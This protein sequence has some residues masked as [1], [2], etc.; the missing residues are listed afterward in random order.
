[1]VPVTPKRFHIIFGGKTLIGISK[2]INVSELCY[3]KKRHWPRLICQ[4]QNTS[5]RLKRKRKRTKSTV[6][7]WSAVFAA[8]IPWDIYTESVKKSCNLSGGS[9]AGHYRNLRCVKCFLCS[10]LWQLAAAI[11][12]EISRHYQRASQ[13]P[14][15]AVRV[16]QFI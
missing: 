13:W 2:T 3:L 10:A 7:I 4:G 5:E 11:R 14:A 12:K 6:F 15:V 16:G 9:S 1:M 8:P